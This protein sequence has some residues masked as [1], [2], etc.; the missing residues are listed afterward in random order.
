M[1]FAKNDTKTKDEF[2]E[3]TTDVANIGCERQLS[4]FTAAFSAAAL[5]TQALTAFLSSQLTTLE[6]VYGLNSAQSGFTAGAN[7][8]G[9]LLTVL[10]FSHFG[11]RWHIPRVLAITTIT[12]GV[13]AFISSSPH[14]IFGVNDYLKQNGST[15]GNTDKLCYSESLDNNATE[16]ECSMG[17]ATV[18]FTYRRMAYAIIVIGMVI[19][20][21]A[22]APRSPLGT[23]YIDN[24]VRI[25]SRTGAYVGKMLC[26]A[27]GAMANLLRLSYAEIA[28]QYNI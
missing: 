12:Y 27:A 24:N 19:Q 28:I 26:Y 11:K 6:K 3:N 8:L 15:S 2:E 10:I 16:L 20:G 22:K 13:A 17:S 5:V 4:A 23:A 21:M 9:F 14:F 1:G 25:Q 18:S 7:D